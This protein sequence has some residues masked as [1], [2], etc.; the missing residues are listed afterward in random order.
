MSV[1]HTAAFILTGMWVPSAYEKGF[2]VGAD[3]LLGVVWCSSGGS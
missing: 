3:L 2:T 1:L